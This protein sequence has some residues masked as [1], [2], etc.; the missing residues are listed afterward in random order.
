MPVFVLLDAW[1][2]YDRMNDANRTQL[3]SNLPARAFTFTLCR[4]LVVSLRSF[5]FLAGKV[6]S[7]AMAGAPSASFRSTF[8]LFN[9]WSRKG[10]GYKNRHTRQQSNIPA[11][12]ALGGWE[13]TNVCEAMTRNGMMSSG[14]EKM[15][16]TARGHHR[17]Q[18]RRTKSKQAR[19]SFH[20]L[21]RR[22]TKVW[23]A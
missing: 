6:N 18:N 10:P 22:H 12:E 19:T 7:N 9:F 16:S 3:N 15:S 11:L 2:R 4:W 20:C 8:F 17:I 23:L 21:I 13:V 14:K 5:A 1:R